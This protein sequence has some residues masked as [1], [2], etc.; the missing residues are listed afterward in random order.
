MKRVAI[1]VVL[2]LGLVP[3]REATTRTSQN[4]PANSMVGRAILCQPRGADIPPVFICSA[5]SC[6]A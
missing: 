6:T 4:R 5:F 3:H 2:V 1:T